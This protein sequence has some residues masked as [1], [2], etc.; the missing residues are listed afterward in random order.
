MNTKNLQIIIKGK[1]KI[2]IVPIANQ[3][4][5]VQR[6]GKFYLNNTPQSCR[7]LIHLLNRGWQL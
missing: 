3:F 5:V 2:K 7:L 1:R 4:A 6:K